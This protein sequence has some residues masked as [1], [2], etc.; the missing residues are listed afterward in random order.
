MLVEE[1]VAP[2][3]V[4]QMDVFCAARQW[5]GVGGRGGSGSQGDLPR[6]TKSLAWVYI[7]MKTVPQVF[8]A[9]RICVYA[10]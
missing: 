1:S 10:A 5:G 8:T 6:P 9:T 2:Q 4:V 7:A 3:C